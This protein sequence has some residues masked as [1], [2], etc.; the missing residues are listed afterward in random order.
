MGMN[1]QT[2]NVL[3]NLGRSRQT[4]RQ[5]AAMGLSCVGIAASCALCAAPPITEDVF[6]TELAPVLTA[7]PIS[8]SPLDAPA[9]VT[10]IDRETIRDSGFIE[11]H[12]LFRLVPGFQ[13][14]DWPEGSPVVVNQGLGDP[15]SKHLLVLIDGQAV[16]NPF[17][18]GVDWQDLSLRPD[19]ISGWGRLRLNHAIIRIAAQGVGADLA[20]DPAAV[21]KDN[22]LKVLPHN[23]PPACF[24]PRC[25]GMGGAWGC[26]VTGLAT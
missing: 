5:L 7:S 19:D 6:L 15:R 11:L 14:A 23:M 1:A 9:A 20:R 26:P 3:P 2:L 21:S 13:V 25:S 18:G 17:L 24:G 16:Y 22:D 4:K 12:D 8:Q 10:V